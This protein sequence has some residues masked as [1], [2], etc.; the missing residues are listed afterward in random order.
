M[1]IRAFQ[2]ATPRLH[3]SVFVADGAQVIGNVEMGKNPRSGTTPSSA[4]T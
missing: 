2:G 1:G 3:P 4:G